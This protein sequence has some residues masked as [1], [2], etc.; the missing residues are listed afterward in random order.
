VFRVVGR[1]D[2]QGRIAGDFLV[3]RFGGGRLAI[4]HDGEAY[5]RGLAQ[6]TKKRL[7]E[8]GINEVFFEARGPGK[9]DYSDV[10]LEL[11]ALGV[12][13]STKARQAHEHGYELQMVGGD[14]IGTKD[15]RRAG[16]RRRS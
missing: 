6:E 8:L 13:F 11:R 12:R 3:E 14:R 10:V 7:N 4:L 1:D 16:S 15:D 2:V 9:A 5:G